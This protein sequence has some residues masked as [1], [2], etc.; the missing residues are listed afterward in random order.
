MKKLILPLVVL[1][2]A[3]ASAVTPLWMRD[4]KFRLTAVG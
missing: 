1:V 2:P 4:A 3:V